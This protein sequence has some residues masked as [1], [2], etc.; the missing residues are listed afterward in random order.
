VGGWLIDHLISWDGDET[1][2]R[3]TVLRIGMLLGFA[4]LGAVF[5]TTVDWAIMWISI[6]LGWLAAA[7]PVAWSLPSP[8]A[9]KGGTGT[10]GG[11]MNF[12]GNLGVAASV[13]TGYIVGMTNPFSGAFLSAAIVLLIGIASYVGLLGRIEPIPDQ[14][15]SAASLPPAADA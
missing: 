2:V 11:I 9:P 4:V 10:V 6:A 3:K 13:A 7:A 1:R 15:A 12:A 14:P 5:T 8:S